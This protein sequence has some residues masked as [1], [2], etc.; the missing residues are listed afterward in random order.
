M[1]KLISLVM[2]FAVLLSISLQA[3]AVEANDGIKAAAARDL[4]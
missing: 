3:S 2:A 1:K 4:N